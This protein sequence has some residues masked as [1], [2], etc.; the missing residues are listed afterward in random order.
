MVVNWM[1]LRRQ[2]FDVFLY[3]RSVSESFSIARIPYLPG[4]NGI[5]DPGVTLSSGNEIYSYRMNECS[6]LLIK[7][8]PLD[9][10]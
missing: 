9:T 1:D 10:F 8:I 6:R 4:N 2:D 3:N 7:H 5:V